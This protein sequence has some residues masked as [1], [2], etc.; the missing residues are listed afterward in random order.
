MLQPLR[1]VADE[2]ARRIG[3]DDLAAPAGGRDA[4]RAVDLEAAVVVAD[5][6]GAPGVD[7]DARPERV[8]GRP[9]MTAP[10]ARWM[11]DGRPG[12]RARHP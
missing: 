2:G 12:G 11:V 6:V 1:L 9:A 10:C 5:P 8:L 3:D 4:G 7:A